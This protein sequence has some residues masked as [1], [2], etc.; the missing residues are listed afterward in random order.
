MPL[1][2]LINPKLGKNRSSHP[3]DYA[4]REP[5]SILAL[6]SYVNRFGIEVKIIDSVLYEEEY[7]LRK[8]S[9]IFKK[10]PKPLLIGFSVMTAQI[11]HALELSDF[12]KSLD[13]SIPIVWGGVHA[14]LFPE[15]TSLDDSIDI[16]VYGRGELSL[17]K[18]C[19]QLMSE[20]KINGLPGTCIKGKLNGAEKPLEITEYP[21]LN[22]ELLDLKRYLGPLP[23]YLLSEEPNRALQ[24]ISSRG[25]PWRCGYCINKVTGNRWTPL[26]SE[27]YL[28][29][30]AANVKR[31]KLDAY[32]VMDE[33]FFVNKRRI[34]EIVEGLMKRRITLTWG[35]NIRAN[36]FRDDY[37][38]LDFARKL[39]STG[40]KFLS[41]GA[42]SGNQ[43][44][45]NLITKDILVE[46]NIHS[47]EVCAEA[48]ITPI[49][50][51]MVGIPTQT[52]K[53]I[54][55][56]IEVIV[57]I[58]HICPSA[59]HYPF[60]IFRPFPG[61]SLYNLCVENGLRVPETLR[62]WNEMGADEDSNTGFYSLDNLPWIKDTEFVE[63]ISKY[64]HL[65][66]S[67]KNENLKVRIYARLLYLII[68]NWD[69]YI[70]R[71]NLVFLKIVVNLNKFF[72]RIKTKVPK[73]YTKKL[74]ATMT[75]PKN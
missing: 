15:E 56:T 17:L 27:R 60:W 9:N 24:V 46:Q 65:I 19:N 1:I 61:G 59:I 13:P 72:K 11:S 51:W 67:Q 64:A 6:G 52:R 31:F 55:D 23:H 35:A 69:T 33:D 68:N 71:I 30:L 74:D 39:K 14:T 22:Y 48:G 37:V 49:Y 7:I 34:F 66:P 58:S 41:L 2:V 42:E 44:V 57:E 29:E 53:E 62:D 50:S 28:D 21:F 70:A 4:A 32:R 43:R 5:L 26:S 36:Y 10:K 40:C 45:L 73:V 8:I 16:V 75:N 25:C 47:A 3:K 63:F 54:L 38:S 18:I 20:K 12:V